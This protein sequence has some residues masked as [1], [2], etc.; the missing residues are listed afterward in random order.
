VIIVF[1]MPEANDKNRR[2]NTAAL[3]TAASS[4]TSPMYIV[5]VLLVLGLAYSYWAHT[6]DISSSDSESQ[7]YFNQIN[8]R[9][10]K[11]RNH[12]K[13]VAANERKQMKDGGAVVKV[14][15]EDE[16]IVKPTPSPTPYTYVEEKINCSELSN[17][18]C[19][20]CTQAGGGGMCGWCVI[21]EQCVE[22]TEG[23]CAMPENHVSMRGVGGQKEC[24]AKGDELKWLEKQ[25]P[26]FMV[27]SS[28]DAPKG[29]EKIAWGN[30][31]L[32][33]AMAK[34]RAETG[35]PT[36][37]RTSLTHFFEIHVPEGWKQLGDALVGPKDG[38]RPELKKMLLERELKRYKDSVNRILT[39]VQSIVLP[40][41][42]AAAPNAS[43]MRLFVV[44][45][46]I[47]FTMAKAHHELEMFMMMSFGA[48]PEYGVDE[49]K[50]AAA[51]P[52]LAGAAAPR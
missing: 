30:K 35:Q 14:W 23:P 19:D 22:D 2:A 11:H 5:P 50:P 8:H 3:K 10:Q 24:P 6:T 43:L 41:F 51:A 44:L 28:Q 26:P 12:M 27:M 48:A 4:I 47:Q 52:K 20:K 45:A 13:G 15:L 36:V 32:D 40:A 37:S 1:S 7:E 31:K 9:F 29:S 34:L 38:G 21:A 16:V 39:Q 33:E 49:P 17:E 18:G 42:D 46:T 25:S